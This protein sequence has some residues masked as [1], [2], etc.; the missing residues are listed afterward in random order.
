MNS[1]P[2]VIAARDFNAKHREW[3]CRQSNR[4]GRTLLAAADSHGLLIHAPAEPTY[5]N[6]RH[7]PDILDI[8]ISRNCPF[9]LELIKCE[10]LSSDHSPVFMFLGSQ[11]GPRA[12]ANRGQFPARRTARRAAPR[13]HVPPTG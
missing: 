2:A 1:G 4:N 6:G 10:E 8:A 12:P 11:A 9:S 3:S 13:V 7:P 5:H